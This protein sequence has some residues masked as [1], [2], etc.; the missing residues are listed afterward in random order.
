[1]GAQ[2]NTID[3]LRY[4]EVV[5]HLR[6]FPSDKR[7]E[8]I[9]RLGIGKGD[10]EAASEKW[11]KARDA[12]RLSGTLDL[13]I[14][15]GRALV[16][17]RERLSMM[18]P[19]VESLGPLPS[20]A[21]LAVANDSKP[22]RLG[23]PISPAHPIPPNPPELHVSLGGVVLKQQDPADI[24]TSPVAPSTV[25]ASVARPPRAITAGISGKVP[26]PALPFT[27]AGHPLP[28]AQAGL[29]KDTSPDAPASEAGREPEERETMELGAVIMSPAVPFKKPV[30]TTKLSAFPEPGPSTP[31]VGKIL[32]RFDPQTGKPLTTPLWIDDPT[33]D[34][35]GGKRK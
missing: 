10:W 12:E 29:I 20:P 23:D 13:S 25:P 4:A 22:P 16:A 30:P 34:R 6:H 14:Q 21:P 1:M 28:V 8:V 7:D 26:R 11:K 33:F 32:V 19:S 24:M 17:A 2:V 18:R 27:P 9:A 35:K 3:I 15:F 5:A 31:Q